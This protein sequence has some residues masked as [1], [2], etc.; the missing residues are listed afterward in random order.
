[1]SMTISSRRSRQRPDHRRRGRGSFRARRAVAG[2]RYLFDF[3]YYEGDRIALDHAGFGL[4]G[5]GSLAAAGVN[6]VYAFAPPSL[7]YNGPPP[8]GPTIIE[9][10]SDV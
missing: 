2:R 8:A 4:S 6:F 9:F 1:M 3:A 7:G 5:T 10:G